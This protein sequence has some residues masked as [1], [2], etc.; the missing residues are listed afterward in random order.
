[1]LALLLLTLVSAAPEPALAVDVYVPLCDSSLIACG[2]GA[3]GDPES[4]DGNLYWGALYGAERYLSHA[5]RF[6]AVHR[7]DGPDSTRPYLLREVQLVRAAGAGEREVKLRL[8]AYSGKHIDEALHDFFSAAA[9]ATTADLVVWAG[10]DRLMDVAAPT[11]TRSARARPSAVLACSSEAFFGP[12]LEQLGSPRLA[13]TRSFMAP[14]AYLLEALTAAIASHG[15][16]AR[17]EVRAA[18]IG[19]YAH[20]QRISPRAAASVFATLER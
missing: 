1:M 17:A 15:I 9:G 4:L 16:D 3:A 18:L 8:L 10:H 19:A 20:Y 14:E 5:P 6:R 12:A 11:L 13:M 2:G 7:I